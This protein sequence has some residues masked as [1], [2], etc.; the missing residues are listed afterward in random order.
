MS[1]TGASYSLDRHQQQVLTILTTEAV[2]VENA[3]TSS[4]LA[5]RIGVTEP[6][7]NPITRKDILEIMRRTGVPIG[8]TSEGYFV[9][10]TVGELSVYLDHLDE[11][12]GGI[13]E[14]KRLVAANFERQGALPV[15]QR[16]LQEFAVGGGAD[17]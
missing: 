6:N 2:G 17:G 11:R 9:I 14:R 8:S 7:G 10:A 4:T 16:S 12:I 13:E 3:I 15:A 5:D 1:D